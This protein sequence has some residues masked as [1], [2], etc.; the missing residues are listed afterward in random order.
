[1]PFQTRKFREKKN[2]DN[3]LAALL[4]RF[5]LRSAEK[6]DSFFFCDMPS[7][8]R[9]VLH[10]KYFQVIARA[11][12][13][14]EFL[15]PIEKNYWAT[16]LEYVHIHKQSLAHIV[17]HTHTRRRSCTHT[18]TRKHTYISMY[19][20]INSKR[21]LLFISSI[22]RTERDRHMLIVIDMVRTIEKDGDNIVFCGR[23]VK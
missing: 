12:T 20:Y 11:Q 5:S 15:Q 17:T 13:H 7:V 8:V 14:G 22:D 1:M 10:T 18:D 6:N 16:R 3:L 19:M 9:I 2:S 4:L 23:W 21:F